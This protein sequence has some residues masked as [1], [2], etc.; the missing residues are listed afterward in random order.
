MHICE[1]HPFICLS[2]C[3]S[4]CVTTNLVVYALINTKLYCKSFDVKSFVVVEMEC[5]S[6][7]KIHGCMVVLCG[8]ILLQRGIIANSLENFCGYRS[9]HKNCKTF[10]P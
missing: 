10:L 4:V 2:I 9:I 8:Q 3:L 1:K 7:E 6:L 5:N